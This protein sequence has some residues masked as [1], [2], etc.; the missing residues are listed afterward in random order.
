MSAEN[1][2]IV[3]RVYDA[4][5]R[6][7][8]EAVFALYDPEVEFDFRRGPLGLLMGRGLYSGHAGVRAW[9]RDRY[10]AWEAIEDDCKE[11]IDAGDQVISVVAT[12]GRGRA[13]GAEVVMTHYGVWTIREGRIVRVEWL[14]TRED[15]LESAGLQQ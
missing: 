3:R 5:A 14:G 12:T 13:S 6:D 7:D 9:V 1:V 15:A 11:L 8:H 4:V 2:E 10:E